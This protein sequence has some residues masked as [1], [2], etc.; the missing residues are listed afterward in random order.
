VEK[1]TIKEV[2][3]AA[4]VSAMTISR[5]V[6]NHPDVASATRKRIQQ[7]I[8]ELGYA[9]NAM[10]SSLRQGRSNILGIVATGIEYFGP[11]RTLVGIEQHAEELGYS[12]LLDLL[13]SP[14][15]YH[16]AEVLESML[17]RQVDGILWA[18]PEIG[19]NR[20]GLFERVRA[21]STPVVFLSSAPREGQTVAAVDNFAGG[22][23]ATEH[24]LEQGQP[25]DWHHQRAD[26]LVGSTAARRRLAQRSPGRGNRSA[27]GTHYLW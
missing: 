21:I 3:E 14:D 17:A 12:L 11:S 8:N 1:L 20:V 15:A 4:G 16:S 18:V 22:R 26:G 19:S 7:I 2:A 5:V 9:P 6:N 27:R 25:H 10:A 23:L 24:L 13:K